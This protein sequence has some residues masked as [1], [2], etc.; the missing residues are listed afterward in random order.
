MARDLCRSGMVNTMKKIS[1]IIPTKNRRDM[2]VKTLDNILAQTLPASEIIVVDNDSSDG[3][4]DHVRRHY[5]DS[6]IIV[7]NPGNQSPGGTRNHG[8]TIATGD[9]IQ[10][11]DSDD[12]MTKNKFEEQSALLEKTG[13]P[14]VYGPFVPVL[15]QDDGSFIQ[16]D[17]IIQYH[18]FP[19]G[20]TLRACMT[21]GYFL[22]IQCF[23]FDRKYVNDLGFWRDDIMSFEDWD[24]LWRIAC[25]DIRPVHSNASAWF[26]RQHQNQITGKYMSVSSRDRDRI[27]SHV[28]ALEH[29]PGLTL[30]EKKML[31]GQ[32]LSTLECLKTE[33]EYAQLFS[34]FNTRPNRLAFDY[35]LAVNRIGKLVTHSRWNTMRGVSRSRTAYERYLSLMP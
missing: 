31:S 27:R 20:K 1:V 26:Y 11:F 30:M 18:P 5:R 22:M 19:A 25:R 9:F 17:V 7:K 21:S 8:L 15:V 29:T 24:Y 6:V 13:S 2:L 3:T 35:Y 12:F 23:L 28:T 32:I 16:K 4:Y 14:M 34:R 33:P 10:F